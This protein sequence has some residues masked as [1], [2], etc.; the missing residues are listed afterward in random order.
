MDQIHEQAQDEVDAALEQ[1]LG[2]PRP[3]A[4]EVERHTYAPSPVD[5]VYPKDYT[6]L[7]RN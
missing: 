2:E 6:G 3:T 4:A 1:A 7:P 5:A